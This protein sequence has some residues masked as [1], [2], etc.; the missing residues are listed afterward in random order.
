MHSHPW[1]LRRVLPWLGTY[2]PKNILNILVS[3]ILKRKWT[4]GYG[5]FLASL[6]W[7]CGFVYSTCIVTGFM[8]V[9][10]C[11]YLI[12]WFAPMCNYSSGH[13][14]TSLPMKRL[15]LVSRGPSSKAN[16]PFFGGGEGSVSEKG[17][18]LSAQ[19]ITNTYG[20]PSATKYVH[21]LCRCVIWSWHDVC[22]GMRL[23][24]QQIAYL[25]MNTGVGFVCLILLHHHN[26]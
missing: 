19:L 3:W 2:T 10:L 6:V 12:M 23:G 13:S 5:Y 11:D 1:W 7:I 14:A 9:S 22:I 8:T 25:T 20:P 17:P 26:T 15:S 21:A 18:R 24:Q 16:S 4:F